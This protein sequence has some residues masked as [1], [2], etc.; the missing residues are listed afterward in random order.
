MSTINQ[1]K[2]WENE[3]RKMNLKTTNN[4]FQTQPTKMNFMANN[5]WGRIKRSIKMNWSKYSRTYKTKRVK[6][7]LIVLNKNIKRNS[8]IYSFNNNPNNTISLQIINQI[9]R[10]G[11]QVRKKEICIVPK[12][13]EEIEVKSKQKGR[14]LNI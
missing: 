6:R 9:I 10:P 14:T 2:S 8:L 7:N 12:R 5:S 1:K 4:T 13:R 3:C 11:N